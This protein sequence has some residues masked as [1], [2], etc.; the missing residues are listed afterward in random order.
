MTIHRTR[1]LLAALLMAASAGTLL[2]AQETGEV[3]VKRGIIEGDLYLAGRSVDVQA[4]VQGDVAAAGRR[5]S[6][7][8]RVTGDVL[9]AG[10]AVTIH[11]QVLDDVR[12]AGRSVIIAGPVAGHVVAAG[13]TVDIAHAARIGEWAWLAGREVTV[14]GRVGGELKAAGQVVIISGEVGGDVELMAEEIRILGGARLDGD[15]V[16][17]SDNE[18][19][20]AEDAVIS[21]DIIA[22]PLP[23]REPEGRGGGVVMLAALAVAAILYFLLFP[24]FSVAGAEALGQAPLTALGLGVAFLFAT[25]FVILML[26]ATL[27]GVLVAL[28]LL[29]WY[30]VS[31]LGGMLTGVIFVGNTGLRLLPGKA[32]TK[33]RG[34][35]VVSIVVALIAIILIQ[36][37]PVGGALAVLVLF[38]LGLGALQL[39]VWRRYSQ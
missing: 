5:V 19:Q 22:R 1:G 18:P 37:I 33:T 21:G 30:L 35:R 4:E 2:F 25:P 24:V 31:L 20:I 8:Q 11:A 15:L 13:E 28:P 39:Q 10:E 17:R 12:A 6:I 23:H 27:I 14:A 9:A 32:G 7:D 26:I 16:Y 34:L 38:L 29:A 36:F 3:V